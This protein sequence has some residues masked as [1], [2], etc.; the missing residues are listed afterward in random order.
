MSEVPLYECES[1]DPPVGASQ[2][3]EQPGSRGKLIHPVCNVVLRPRTWSLCQHPQPAACGHP[4]PTVQGNLAHKE[5]PTPLGPPQGPRRIPT[6]G[7]QGVAISYERGTPAHLATR[8]CKHP[9]P[10]IDRAQTVLT[11]GSLRPDRGTSLIRNTR[12][13]GPYIRPI[14]RVIWWSYGG[15]LFLMPLSPWAQSQALVRGRALAFDYVYLIH[16][17]RA[18]PTGVPRL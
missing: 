1:L 16:E 17:R 4:F 2:R 7:A 14:P 8:R 11:D 9:N 15:G 5:M 3:S 12:L 6:V 13:L 18:R 10:L